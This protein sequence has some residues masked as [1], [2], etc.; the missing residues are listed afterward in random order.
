MNLGCNFNVQ[1][2][3]KYSTCNVTQMQATETMYFNIVIFNFI[4][5]AD[6]I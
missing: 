6:E 3:L 5:Q 2:V 1:V 4:I